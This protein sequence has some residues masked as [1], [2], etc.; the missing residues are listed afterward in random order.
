MSQKWTTLSS[1][2]V[3]I[4][5]KVDLLY[6]RIAQ[7]GYGHPIPKKYL[8]I[9]IEIKPGNLP[10]RSNCLETMV[11]HPM[12]IDLRNFMRAFAYFIDEQRA[13]VNNLFIYNEENNWEDLLTEEEKLERLAA[14]ERFVTGDDT[15][16]LEY[17][18]HLVF[19]SALK[20]FLL[21]LGAVLDHELFWCD[22]ERVF[23]M[24]VQLAASPFFYGSEEGEKFFN[25]LMEALLRVCSEDGDTD[26]ISASF[27][28][29]VEAL[30]ELI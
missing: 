19:R 30:A 5:E 28:N 20:G 6:Q 26:Q 24:L 8:K 9:A 25:L 29:D 4:E 27:L 10:I 2:P 13:Y 18:Y 12:I 14:L 23:I 17:P 1:Y 7:Q 3:S 16:N 21:R 11:L 22:D 15:S